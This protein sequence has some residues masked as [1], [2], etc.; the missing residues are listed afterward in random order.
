MFVLALVGMLSADVARGAGRIGATLVATDP[1]P[2]TDFA[3][4]DG[5]LAHVFGPVVGEE[6]WVEPTTASG[7]R[8]SSRQRVTQCVLGAVGPLADGGLVWVAS[9]RRLDVPDLAANGPRLY[10]RDDLEGYESCAKAASSLDPAARAAFD[11][12]VGRRWLASDDPAERTALNDTGA[13]ASWVFGVVW[14]V[15]S[16]VAAVRGRR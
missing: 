4:L 6:L 5:Q 7:L 3:A 16:L 2:A 12:S 11:G 9:I 10:Q 1:M 8:G 15:G 13:N 14:A